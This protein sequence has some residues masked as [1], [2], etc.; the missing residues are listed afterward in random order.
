[1]TNRDEFLVFI[2]FLKKCWVFI[3]FSYNMY[4]I[5]QNVPRG[6]NLE[7]NMKSAVYRAKKIRNRRQPINTTINARI[8]NLQ[9]KLVELS[10]AK[11]SNSEQYENILNRI[12]ALRLVGQ[13]K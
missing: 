13:E 1:M 2:T 5:V 11:E 7:N 9:I 4:S 8:K 12:K 6:T 3:I 10:F